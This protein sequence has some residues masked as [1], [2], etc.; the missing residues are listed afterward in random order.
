MSEQDKKASRFNAGKVEGHTLPL[1][2]V[3]EM[4]KVGMFGAAKYDSNNYRLPT[5]STQYFD[6]AYRHMVKYLYGQEIDQDSKCHH[7]AHAAWNIL[8]ELEK[9]LTGTQ[10]DDRYKY[11]NINEILDKVFNLNKEQIEAAELAIQRKQK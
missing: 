3:T 10:L 6:C 11:A 4:F 5:N 2:A 7:L 1:L 8:A 9:V